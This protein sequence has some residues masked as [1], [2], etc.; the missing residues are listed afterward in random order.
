MKKQQ[1]AILSIK[2]IVILLISLS[3]TFSYSNNE[4]FSQL[5]KYNVTWKELGESS[6][7]AMPIGNGDIGVNVWT[8][9][10]GD[11][12]FLIGKNDAWGEEKS[13][14]QGMMSVGRVRISLEPNPFKGAQNLFQSLVLSEGKIVLKSEKAELQ[15]WSDANANV[16]HIE[17]NTDAPTKM[18]VHAQS[19]R[20]EKRDSIGVDT[21]L[22]GLTDE[23]VW[24]YRVNRPNTPIH[25]N[26]IGSLIEGDGLVSRDQ[27][28]LVSKISKNHHV[29]V[30]TFVQVT[31]TI[32]QWIDK[33]NKQV[34][35]TNSISFDIAKQKHIDWW[36]NF[37]NRSWIFVTG[38]KDAES[39]SRGYIL[40]RFIH[41]CTS[42]GDYPIK[43]NGSL[44][45]I[46]RK[47]VHKEE[48]IDLTPDMRR[49]GG[50]YW[51]QN[52]RASYWPMVASG[53][54]DLMQPLFS[55]YR[56]MVEYN[57]K[58]VQEYY[59]HNGFYVKETTDIW[60]GLTNKKLS[61]KQSHTLHYYCTILELS[62][63]MIDYYEYTRDDSF[64]EETLLPVVD[65]AVTFYD[66]H[67]PKNETGKLEIKNANSLES[68][69]GTTNPTPDIAGLHFVLK[70]LLNLPENH[71]TPEQRE[72]WK[73]IASTIPPVATGMKKNK[74]VIFPYEG[75]QVIKRKNSENPDLYAVYPY[76]LYGIGKPDLEI[77][78][79]TYELRD[80][81]RT[82]CW[83]Q[84]AI[85]AAMLG[86]ADN[87]R[88]DI[89]FNFTRKEPE[90]KFPAFWAQGFDHAPD[91]D[92]GGVAMHALQCMLIQSDDGKIHLLPAW[93]KNWNADF[94]LHTPDKTTVQ[95]K[96]VNGKLT[97][98]YVHPESRQ[99]DLIIS[100]I[101]K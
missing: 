72:R 2:N 31:D 42:R 61:K 23:I 1:I 60:G 9:N 37:W 4:V 99:K 7:D 41:G 14:F 70:G 56:N 24:H 53:D 79:S 19:W 36:R 17:T 51:F 90:L 62:A 6:L 34:S 33:M 44:Y 52:T 39:V 32:E 15:I 48:E 65:G 10:N 57:S 96:V 85:N 49:W 18:T 100:D 25:N 97:D 64:I 12:V 91:Q 55:M 13:F 88:K 58:L 86:L 59:G 77:A 35:E 22:E 38:D 3:F 8:E 26:T 16:T 28:T 92:N 27:T 78:K 46:F 81:K 54:F 67:F 50:R 20:T 11:L 80:I 29:R 30:H 63:M 75:E 40:Q 95:A 66:E 87:A 76:R 93:P 71:T 84:D 47:L 45:T 43:F 101:Y 73:K 21:F 68:F 82:G 74:K 98:I 5:E 69:W 89:V 83:R 94:K